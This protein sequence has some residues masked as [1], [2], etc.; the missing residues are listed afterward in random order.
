[1]KNTNAVVLSALGDA[2]RTGAAIDASQIYQA[3]FQ[4]IFVDATATG[5]VKIQMSNDVC[6]SGTLPSSFTPTHWSD[7]PSATS[8]ITSGVGAPIT[9]SITS[10]RWLRVV[11]TR[12]AGGA[13][14][15]TVTMFAIDI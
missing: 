5:T 14:L 3:T 13:S 15:V 6:N 11:F 2:S 10:V 9:L 4:P 7:I 1:M 8:T 12:S